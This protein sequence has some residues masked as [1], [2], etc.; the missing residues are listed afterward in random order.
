MDDGVT[1]AL[2]AEIRE[3]ARLLSEASGVLARISDRLARPVR[4]GPAAD[5]ADF[6]SEPDVAGPMEPERT[7]GRPSAA[8]DLEPRAAVAETGPQAGARD[9]DRIT[10]AARRL[11]ARDPDRWWRAQE[12]A[13]ALRDQGLAGSTLRG[14]AAGAA[15]RL[16]AAGIVDEDS[17]RLRLRAEDDTGD[18]AP[19]SAPRGA[20]RSE[21]P[22]SARAPASAPPAPPA[23]KATAAPR[24]WAVIVARAGELLRA[25]PTRLWK[26]SE[27][28][29]AVQEA[30]PASVGSRR[31]LHFGLLPRLRAAGLIA[32]A[33]DG[34]VCLAATPG[35]RAATADPSP[36]ESSL[37]GEIAMLGREID[38]LAEEQ[39]ALENERRTAR[40]AAWAGRARILQ[41]RL[42]AAGDPA[43]ERERL[44]D[45][46]ARL[47][48]LVKQLGCR[49]VN[50]LS[51]AWEA[52]DWEAYVARN[53][54][55]AGGAQPSLPPAA[56]RAYQRG[57]LKGLQILHRE[58]GRKE[59]ARTILEARAV[60][61]ESDAE[62]ASAMQR[63]GYPGPRLV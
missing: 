18:P 40:V 14:L 24:S 57:A 35:P 58:V 23:A 22:A 49:W 29:R 39:A 20:A 52:E 30:D 53:E 34:R 61:T 6:T 60:L 45:V 5:R 26:L 17:G 12:L 51:S 4:G 8:P 21:E 50:A 46:F 9:W 15:A 27:L 10:E 54:A 62:V 31:G 33:P 7:P 16:R 43:E 32:E 42:R 11:L 48:G 41:E 28:S 1:Q 36:L 2:V 59:A 13:L 19:A 55:V 63:F 3:L 56:E 25:D 47:T 37:R 44:R 38:A